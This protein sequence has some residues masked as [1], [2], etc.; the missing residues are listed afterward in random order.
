VFQCVGAVK[1]GI[2][3]CNGVDDNCDGITDSPPP[4]PVGSACIQ[5]VCATPCG[6]GEFGCPGGEQCLNGYCLPTSCDKIVCPEGL[7]CFNGI[8]LADGG[9]S[10]SSSSSGTTTTT[11]GGGAGGSMTGAGGSGGGS[12]GG[13]TTGAG[14]SSSS[15]NVFG[16]ATGGGGCR[17]ALPGERDDAP[18]RAALALM[19]LAL[20]TLHR[21]SARRSGSS[22]KG[23]AR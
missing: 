9:M 19:A 13:S 16:L 17:C 3:V 2:E 20:A 1:P 4:C 21:R 18:S 10:S 22:S 5:G 7:T 15:G 8:C 14:G 12:G 23:E 11:S 6:P